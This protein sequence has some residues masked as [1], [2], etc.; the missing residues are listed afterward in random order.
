MDFYRTFML[1]WL[2]LGVVSFLGSLR[3]R[4]PY[5]RHVRP[6]WGPTLPNR[7]G[8]L[9]MEVPALVFYNF[10]LLRGHGETD[11]N[12]AR[13]VLASAYNV[14][15]LYRALVFPFRLRTQ[16]KRIPLSI[17]LMAVAFNLGNGW[18]LGTWFGGRGIYE[19]AWLGDPR[20]LAGAAIFLGGLAV[21]VWADGRLIGLRRAGG[22][23]YTIPRGGLFERV[24]CPNHLGEMVEWTGYAIMS[25][26]APPA[27][28]ACWTVLNVLPRSLAHHRWYRDTFE[29]YPPQRKAVWPGIL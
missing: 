23:G 26:A 29:D 12:A 28:F 19:A 3:I 18:L 17:V 5:G 27:V 25:W 24:S 15:Y 11:W 16:G 8:W 14:H 7:A 1:V 21:N 2:A 10:F 13:V 20:F 9:L 4:A 6:G 22:T